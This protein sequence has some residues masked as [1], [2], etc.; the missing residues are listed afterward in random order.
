MPTINAEKQLFD[1]A[2]K[3][4]F[5]YKVYSDE[6]LRKIL[7]RGDRI[8]TLNGLLWMRRELQ[9]FLKNNL[10]KFSNLLTIF[11]EDRPEALEFILTEKDRDG[12]NLRDY[13]IA[14]LDQV[15]SGSLTVIISRDVCENGAII[16]RVMRS[17]KKATKAMVQCILDAEEA[18]SILTGEKKSE[19]EKKLGLEGI[20]CP[21]KKPCTTT[22][23]ATSSTDSQVIN[24]AVDQ[25]REDLFQKMK[26]NVSDF[27]R[28]LNGLGKKELD[29]ILHDSNKPQ[30]LAY[31]MEQFRAAKEKEHEY[32]WYIPLEECHNGIKVYTTIDAVTATKMM[33]KCILEADPELKD[34]HK[35]GI[36]G[37]FGLANVTCPQDLDTCSKTGSSS[38]TDSSMTEGSS[39]IAPSSTEPSNNE[40]ASNPS[41]ID[42]TTAKLDWN[43]FDVAKTV[44]VH[45][46]KSF[47]DALNLHKTEHLVS[48]LRRKEYGRTVTISAAT[49]DILASSLLITALT[50]AIQNPSVF[51][52]EDPVNAMLE[53]IYSNSPTLVAQLLL[54]SGLQ[55]LSYAKANYLPVNSRKRT[56]VQG[57]T[58]LNSAYGLVK[59]PVRTAIGMLAGFGSY[60]ATKSILNRALPV[61]STAQQTKNSDL[62]EVVVVG[63]SIPLQSLGSSATNT[64]SEGTAST[65]ASTR[66]SASTT[67]T[68]GSTASTHADTSAPTAS[69]SAT[70]NN[71]IPEERKHQPLKKTELNTLIEKF[72]SVEDCLQ[73]LNDKIQASVAK[74]DEIGITF[75][76]ESSISDHLT[77]FIKLLEALLESVQL[78]HEALKDPDCEA[79][80]V[81]YTVQEFRKQTANKV[82]AM[83]NRP[84]NFLFDRSNPDNLNVMGRLRGTL[85]TI[86]STMEKPQKKKNKFQGIITSMKN[87]PD[88]KVK[89]EQAI[90][91]KYGDLYNT[92]RALAGYA[93]T[94]SVQK[95]SELETWLTFLAKRYAEKDHEI[96]MIKRA[97]WKQELTA[98]QARKIS[99]D[100]HSQPPDDG[101]RK[102]W[103]VASLTTTSAFFPTQVS[104]N[105]ETQ[106]DEQADEQVPLLRTP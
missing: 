101:R 90:T 67:S 38:M 50:E 57:V 83:I 20:S 7:N 8:T 41:A 72:K 31:A 70:A 100:G 34:E 37:I 98:P 28:L 53:D 12:K 15:E 60:F 81:E 59:A 68:S 16:S 92:L 62:E 63:E 84:L 95:I 17:S 69:T 24:S 4:S 18:L 103:G 104:L 49:I 29:E 73:I 105:D 11:V 78:Q 52:D 6:S 87:D 30:L 33:I 71:I 23:A 10:S 46:V 21:I 58:A 3:Q 42:S 19:I 76:D 27:I 97:F 93:E 54:N 79:L 44:G 9:S 85:A 13:A 77:P 40:S 47:F 94:I 45:A 32:E 88:R 25:I 74:A 82:S 91:D 75:Y 14:Q 26:T 55:A 102:T 96:D 65:S 39:S 35:K 64:S 86:S 36:E 66:T 89:E 48:Y 1:Y 99:T 51:Q 22:T 43:W 2:E 106:S 56:L 61:P 80:C 5:D